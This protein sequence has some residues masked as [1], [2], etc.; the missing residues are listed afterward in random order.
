MPGALFYHCGIISTLGNCWSR[1]MSRVKLVSAGFAAILLA[2]SGQHAMAQGLLQIEP[3][4][5]NSL[6]SPYPLGPLQK[7]GDFRP[8]WVSGLIPSPQASAPPQAPAAQTASTAQPPARR[9]QTAFRAAPQ[10]ERQRETVG[11]GSLLA[12]APRTGERRP[13]RP[14][15]FPSSIL[16]I[17][18]NPSC[19]G[20]AAAARG[21]FEELLAE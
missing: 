4:P 1:E 16:H 19:Y 20:A 3:H 10:H 2:W 9:R 15:C 21:R 5:L 17:Q 11:S 8:G 13:S 6:E 7:F 12:L 18:Q 14:F